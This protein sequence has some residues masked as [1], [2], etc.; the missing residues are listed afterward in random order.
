MVHNELQC[1]QRTIVIID[2]LF[3]A[4]GEAAEGARVGD[5]HAALQ[6]E[7]LQVLAVRRLLHLADLH[8]Q[9]H[10]DDALQ[11]AREGTYCRTSDNPLFLF[12]YLF[13][14]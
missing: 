8:L 3:V 1:T 14:C 11:Q 7:E 10:E 6:R 13:F 4:D 5:A 12:S 9:A 2:C